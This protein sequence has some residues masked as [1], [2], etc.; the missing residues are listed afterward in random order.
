MRATSVS[1]SNGI[2]FVNVEPVAPDRAIS[3]D[4]F[5]SPEPVIERP[6]QSVQRRTSYYDEEEERWTSKNAGK[7]LIVGIIIG[8][9]VFIPAII[10][11]MPKPNPYHRGP[12]QAGNIHVVDS[13]SGV[14]VS[15]HVSH[16]AVWVTNDTNDLNAYW[17]INN[18]TIM[19]GIHDVLASIDPELQY[20]AVVM[21]TFGLPSSLYN[22]SYSI[23][24]I[25]ASDNYIWLPLA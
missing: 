25:T 15:T 17:W 6:Y 3:R 16:F 14:D 11:F 10:A 2:E 5:N 24:I 4:P 23:D 1:M 19:P 20:K 18:A 22:G 8:L 9:A 7:I 12:F 13:V 21:E